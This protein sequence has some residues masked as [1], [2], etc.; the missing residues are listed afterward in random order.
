MTKFMNLQRLDLASIQLVVLCAESG[1]LSEAARRCHLSL[2][3]ASH[4]LKAFEDAVGEPVFQRHRR[5]LRITPRGRHVVYCGMQLLDWVARLAGPVSS[6]GAM[7]DRTLSGVPRASVLPLPQLDPSAGF[8]RF[9][10]TP[11]RMVSPN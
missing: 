4:R 11:P 9:E 1:S 2:S 5:G 6:D 8:P 3:G 7:P 10:G